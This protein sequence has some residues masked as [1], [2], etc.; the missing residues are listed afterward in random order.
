VY[1]GLVHQCCQK[2]A[3]I[4]S[5]TKQLHTHKFQAPKCSNM[6]T[7]WRHCRNYAQTFDYSADSAQR[8]IYRYCHGLWNT[9]HRL[10]LPFAIKTHLAVIKWKPI[11]LSIE[12]R[13]VDHFAGFE[14]P[15]CAW[16]LL[17]M[18]CE[19]ECCLCLLSWQLRHWRPRTVLDIKNWLQELRLD[20]QRQ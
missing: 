14:W 12:L 8:F 19:V 7:C 17:E 11:E 10:G 16:R 13:N 3:E 4:R 6:L 18:T 1:D 2:T 15:Q 20:N 5:F 9:L